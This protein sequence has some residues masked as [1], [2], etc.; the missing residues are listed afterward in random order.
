MCTVIGARHVTEWARHLH[1]VNNLPIGTQCVRWSIFVAVSKM[2]TFNR[3]SM[4]MM[5]K[6]KCFSRM[7]NSFTFDYT[8]FFQLINCS[9]FESLL[10]TVCLLFTVVCFDAKFIFECMHI[11]SSI[12][13][14]ASPNW[15]KWC[16]I[17]CFLSKDSVVRWSTSFRMSDFNQWLRHITRSSVLSMVG[18]ISSLAGFLQVLQ[19]FSQLYFIYCFH[20]VLFTFYV[21]QLIR[22]IVQIH[23]ITA[24]RIEWSYKY[25]SI[26][27]TET[28]G[29][30][31]Q[32]QVKRV[33]WV[34]HCRPHGIGLISQVCWWN[35]TMCDVKWQ[36]P[37]WLE[38]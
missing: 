23:K 34:C 33:I 13:D 21:K 15:Q 26:V 25:L 30:P 24:I 6:I 36:E 3:N 31:C 37:E 11:S 7:S 32:W 5:C 19:I 17:V 18:F 22:S 8:N 35:T 38:L 28:E 29:S 1:W 2:L 10:F 4:L 20:F 9:K 16:W 27:L 12:N 14:D